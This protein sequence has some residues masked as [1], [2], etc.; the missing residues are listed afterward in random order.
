MFIAPRRSANR[1]SP[2]RLARLLDLLAEH[3]DGQAVLDDLQH[4]L[5]EYGH[6]IYN[7]DFVAPT[8]AEDPLPVLLSL[9]ALVQNPDRDVRARQADMVQEREALVDKHNSI[10]QPHLTLAV[11][12]G[13][14]VGA[15]LYT[16]PRGSALLC[17]CGL[18]YT[19]AV[20]P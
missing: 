3:P 7:L 10:S 15:T 12:A 17:G 18:A 2:H 6:Q 20:G 19:A 5:D 1:F 4:Y 16:L 13:S 8:L 9:K 11:P 14:G